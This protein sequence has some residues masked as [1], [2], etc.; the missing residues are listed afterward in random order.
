MVIQLKCIPELPRQA[1]GGNVA[2]RHQIA[3]IGQVRTGKGDDHL[4]RRLVMVHM[5]PET[6]RLD[7]EN[8]DIEGPS[9][10]SRREVRA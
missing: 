10:S 7:I 1:P 2:D 5:G 6:R 3:P 4:S 8:L 9:A